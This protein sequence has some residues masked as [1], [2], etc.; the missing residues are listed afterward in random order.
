LSRAVAA[1]IVVCVA[2][3]NSG[4]DLYTIGSPGAAADA[5][6]VGNMADPGAGGFFLEP[7]SSRGPTADG[8]VKPDLCA[9]GYRIRAA[10]AG[11]RSGYIVGSGTSMS[12]PFIAGT[13]ALMLQAN[14]SLTPAEVK[15][16]L[17]E[18]ADHYGASGDN[19]DFGVGRLDGYAA[20]SRAAGQ[21]GTGPA[22]PG[23]ASGSDHLDSSTSEQMWEL[24]VSDTT[25]PVAATLIMQSAGAD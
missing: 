1:G 12:S 14:P 2:A 21:H 18:T 19:N 25:F 10:Q 22:V 11:T 5:I 23:R 13:V 8:R 24:A 4:P 17:M 15:S 20:L 9:P 6:T 3:G 16:I 7:H